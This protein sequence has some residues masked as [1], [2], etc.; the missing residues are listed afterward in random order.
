MPL[1]SEAHC[2]SRIASALAKGK[3]KL[4]GIAELDDAHVEFTLLRHCCSFGLG[5]FYARACGPIAMDALCDFDKSV[6]ATFENT[7]APLTDRQ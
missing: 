3:A 1:G 5:V 4:A 7:I 2:S 6:R